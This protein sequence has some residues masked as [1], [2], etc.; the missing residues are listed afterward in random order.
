MKS[1]RERIIVFQRKSFAIIRATAR[2]FSDEEGMHLAA[3]VAFYALLSIL[4]AALLFASLSSFFLEPEEITNWLIKRIGEETPVSPD[5]IGRTVQGASDLRGP[6]GIAGLVGT[7][8]SSTLVF[9]AIMR[10]INRTWGF[11]GTGTRTF[12]RRKLWEFGLLVSMAFLVLVSYAATRLFELVREVRFPGT[13]YYF[14]TDSAGWVVFL[15]LFFFLAVSSILMLLYKF[16]PTTTVRWRDVILPSLVAG[17]ALRIA[18]DVLSWYIRSYGYYDTVYGPV[19][20][21]IVLLVWVY[22]SAN[23]VIVGAAMSAALSALS[24]ESSG[25]DV[26]TE[27]NNRHLNSRYRQSPLAQTGSEA[28]SEQG[29]EG[30]SV[31]GEEVND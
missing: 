7:I 26:A 21:V 10:C 29:T 11:V 25:L 28:T 31:N 6:L 23:V 24:Q 20:S 14:V 9:A 27:T 22:V 19:T 15:G 2:I 17:L 4:P 3:G 1:W 8:F 5:F 16:V 18:N 30:S 12:I 13:D